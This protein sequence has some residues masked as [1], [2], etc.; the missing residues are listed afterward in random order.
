M[1][2]IISFTLALVIL[3][4][5]FSVMPL[6]ADGDN[7]ITDYAVYLDNGVHLLFNFTDGST[8]FVPV[9]A[10]E[11]GDLKAPSGFEAVYSVSDYAAGILS[12]SSKPAHMKSLVSA[13]LDYGAAAQKHF[14]Y[15]T[16]NLVGTH[17]ADTDAL[18]GAT[19]PEVIVSDEAGIYLGATLILEATMMLRFYFLRTDITATV[20]GEAAEVKLGSGYS[21]IEVSVMPYEMSKSV[22][23]CCGN[24]TEV[25]YAP[26]NYLKNMLGSDNENFV[27]LLASI[28]AYGRAAESYRKISNCTQHEAESIDFERVATAFYEGCRSGIC[29]ACGEVATQILPKTEIEVIK[30]TGNVDHYKNVSIDGLVSSDDDELHFY[31]TPDDPDG[32]SLYIEYSILFNETLSNTNGGGWIVSPYFT[33]SNCAGK[34]SYDPAFLYTD[35]TEGKIGTFEINLDSD[36]AD[37][38]I[39]YYE[40]DV[41][42]KRD[43]SNMYYVINDFYGWHRIGYEITQTASINSK[44]TGVD[45]AIYMTV[46]VDGVKVL[47]VDLSDK[48]NNKPYNKVY[49]LYYADVWGGELEYM[50]T[51]KDRYVTVLRMCGLDS[52]EEDICLPIADLYV[53]CGNGFVVEAEPLKNPVTEDFTKD[54]VTIKDAKIHFALKD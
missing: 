47:R 37:E 1:K 21:Y 32:K 9:A 44:G 42:S 41:V 23:V 17:K 29:A 45:Y 30:P 52:E 16:E 34:D 22:T 43:F 14:N 51:G 53:T 8:E 24:G 18:A 7:E 46:Y 2:K 36:S 6:A 50:D 27:S 13:M 49:H 20:G 54:G 12:D 26:V 31:P 19:A 39:V 48:L 35:N 38:N 25:T 4:L 10:K 5:T 11:M 40:N 33:N 3:L 28:Y 15:N